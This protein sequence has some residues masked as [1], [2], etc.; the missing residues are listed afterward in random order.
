M[1]LDNSVIDEKNITNDVDEK[2]Y[3]LEEFEYETDNS[4]DDENDNSSNSGTEQYQ[5]LGDT[6][7]NYLKEI[8][9]IPLLTPEQEIDTVKKAQ[10]GDK[11]ARELMINANLRL[12]VS[13]AKHYK[14]N[15]IDMLDLV[16]E[17]NQGL[18]TAVDKFD[19]D[20]GFKFSTYAT[21]W[22]K[23]AITRYI[24]NCGRT[25]RI[26]VHMMEQHGK[27]ERCKKRLEQEL[28]R[29][30]TI[31]EIAQELNMTEEKV[32]QV[33]HTMEDVRSLD[34]PINSDDDGDE[35]TLGEFIAADSWLNP[36]DQYHTTE[37]HS[38]IMEILNEKKADG[39][40]KF[41]SREKEVLLK[42]FGFYGKV[43]TLEEVGK[44]MGV[45]RERIRQIEAKALRK[46][47]MPRTSDK[48]A[49]F[50]NK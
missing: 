46:L 8:G 18:M 20:K 35:S 1:G 7:Y 31:A 44:E 9:N 4:I 33:M 23:Q 5:N 19:A 43:Y 17:G 37:L 12:V 3:N 15:G 26:P 11:D 39:S 36:E 14:V 16:Q 42:R 13:I 38:V 28:Y 41:S 32:L 21:W 29:E 10:A 47:R 24:M 27:V 25:I 30:P 22:I 6:F 40:D 45:T 50:L 34:S 2:E 48:L 49:A